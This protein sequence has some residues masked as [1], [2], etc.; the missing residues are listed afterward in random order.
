M[1]K[2]RTFLVL[3]GARSGKT[4]HALSIAQRTPRRVYLATAQAHDEE[5]RQRIARHQNERDE[6]W[7]TIEEPL[8]IVAAL[9]G[10]ETEQTTVVVDCLTLW[11]SNLLHA[12]RDC[13]AAAD[14]LVDALERSPLTIV[15]VSNEVGLGIVPENAL[16][17]RF[18]DAQGT[19]NQRLAGI[20]DCVDFV[21]AGLV[22][23][24][25]PGANG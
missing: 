1:Q 7:Q 20:V 21:A 12:G 16:A 19:L 11:L 9:A 17:R 5:M 18:R 3:G 4:R 24:L 23:N 8:D 14:A 22:L 15:M 6:Q 2:S 13:D 10:I 25:K